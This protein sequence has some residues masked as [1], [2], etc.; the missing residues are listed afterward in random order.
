MRPCSV[1]DSPD[2][3]SVSEA[4]SSAAT[5][6]RRPPSLSGRG[7]AAVAAVGALLVLGAVSATWALLSRRRV[8]RNRVLQGAPRPLMTVAPPAPPERR[9]ALDLKEKL[10][11]TIPQPVPAPAPDPAPAD[12]SDTENARLRAAVA[13]LQEEV[14]VLR[15][16]NGEVLPAYDSLSVGGNVAPATL[17][18]NFRS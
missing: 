8:R 15:G 10:E 12:A 11:G 1:L 6:S 5:A 14:I 18:R 2:A 3:S 17:T 4:P 13:Q 16:E 7:V 9:R